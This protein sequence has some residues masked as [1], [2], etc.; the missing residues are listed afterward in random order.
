M[1]CCLRCLRDFE[2]WSWVGKI[3]KNWV[4]W[5]HENPQIYTTN[6]VTLI[7]MHLIFFYSFPCFTEDQQILYHTLVKSL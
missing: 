2:K 3:G 5:L 7:G 1:C 4:K 6:S